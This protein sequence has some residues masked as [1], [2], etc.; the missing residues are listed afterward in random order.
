MNRLNTISLV[1]ILYPLIGCSGLKPKPIYMTEKGEKTSTPD[2]DKEVS[3]PTLVEEKKGFPV[4]IDREKMMAQIENLL[5]V[6]YLFGGSTTQGM[7]CSGFVQ[8][9]YIKAVAHPLPRQVAAMVQTGRRV[10]GD[11]L[12]FGDLVFFKDIEEKGTSH[13]GIYL[14]SNQF[15]HASVSKGVI[16]S[17]LNDPYYNI[18]YVKARRITVE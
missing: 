11:K 13:V 15:V 12:Q 16:I 14:D 7:D 9:V 1:L 17:G 18:R 6:P 4:Q 3:Q 2:I 10:V 5:G 8:F